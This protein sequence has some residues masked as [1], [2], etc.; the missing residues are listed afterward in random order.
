M[1]D[2]KK[3]SE[4]LLAGVKQ[5]QA[6]AD[7]LSEDGPRLA[8]ENSALQETIRTIINKI[9]DSESGPSWISLRR[10]VL[11]PRNPKP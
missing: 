4:Q 5:L 8:E 6:D 10:Q 1:D 3:T 2:K 9:L 7:R 11:A